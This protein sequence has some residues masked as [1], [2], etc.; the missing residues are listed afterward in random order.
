M[1]EVNQVNWSV[2]YNHRGKTG[3]KG[4]RSCWQAS[5]DTESHAVCALA[6]A[7]VDHALFDFFL[8]EYSLISTVSAVHDTCFSAQRAKRHT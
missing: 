1:N 8:P 7:A 4:G 3:E 6:R 2:L 5:A